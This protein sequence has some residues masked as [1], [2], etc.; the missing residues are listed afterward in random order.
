ML[1][2]HSRTYAY[3][4][5]YVMP[6]LFA[7]NERFLIPDSYI[8]LPHRDRSKCERGLAYVTNNKFSSFI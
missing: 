2:K 7:E 5:I 8:K 6:M 3:V 4:V 1:L